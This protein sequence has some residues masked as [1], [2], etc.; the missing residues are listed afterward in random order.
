MGS[1]DGLRT[2]LGAAFGVTTVSAGVVISVVGVA[3]VV[4]GLFVLAGSAGFHGAG[5]DQWW[6]ALFIVPLGG[7]FVA[8]GYGAVRL[9]VESMRGR[10]VEVPSP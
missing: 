8:V 9:G 1:L 4:F 6:L 3:V 5:L 7:F 10:R 2:L